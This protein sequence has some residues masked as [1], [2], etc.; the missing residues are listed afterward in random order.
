MVISEPFA[1]LSGTSSL[2]SALFA[3]AGPAVMRTPPTKAADVAKNFLLFIPPSVSFLWGFGWLALFR[4][5]LTNRLTAV[6]KV[7]SV[8]LPC[9]HSS[10]ASLPICSAQWV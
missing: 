4:Q 2:V 1:A 6:N 7:F 10:L 9:E 8:F 5:F 3:Q